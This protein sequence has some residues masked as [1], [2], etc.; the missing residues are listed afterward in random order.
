MTTLPIDVVPSR[1][2]DCGRG[3]GECA[4]FTNQCVVAYQDAIQKTTVEELEQRLEK[5]CHPNK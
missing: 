1:C 5:V 2:P 3:V 4:A